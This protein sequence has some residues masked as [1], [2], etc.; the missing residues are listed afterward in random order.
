MAVLLMLGSLS[1]S[2]RPWYTVDTPYQIAASK[3][4]LTEYE[5]L[6][7]DGSIQAV[8]EMPAGTRAK[9]E[10]SGSGDRLEWIFENGKPGHINYL[11]V[12]FN[13]GM[14]PGSVQIKADGEPMDL[15]ILGKSLV[16]GS[17]VPVK[18]LGVIRLMDGG[19]RDDKILAAPAGSAMGQLAGLEELKEV[20]PG[21]LT[22]CEIWFSHY[23][24]EDQIQIESVENEKRAWELIMTSIKQF[25]S[26]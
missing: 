9:W 26:N 16:R 11:A 14:L 6:L 23:K 13:D 19:V 18:V 7:E 8:V 2:N 24:G 20:F 17:V 15:V 5:P 22:I 10:V 12:P 25:A 3:N 4:F 1:C 21:V